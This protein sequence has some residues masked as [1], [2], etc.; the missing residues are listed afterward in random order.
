[1]TS[2]VP[3]NCNMAVEFVEAYKNAGYSVGILSEKS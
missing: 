3:G 2:G 1:M